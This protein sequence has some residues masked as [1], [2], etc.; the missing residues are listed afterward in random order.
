MYKKLLL[1]IITALLISTGIAQAEPEDV[2]YFDLS[3]AGYRLGMTFDE[4][5]EV[6]PF[7]YIRDNQ[8]NS[9]DV[10]VM[11]A[12]IDQVYIDDI[13]T[14]LWLSFRSG[15]ISKII[16]RFSP[17]ALEDMSRRFKQALGKGENRSK[18]FT[19]RNGAEIQQTICQW[20]FPHA[21]LHL[22]K[23]SSNT[24]YATI[25]LVKKIENRKA[26]TEKADDR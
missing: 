3:L 12:Y 7:Q 9:D 5:A 8:E 25:S 23:I 17:D 24:E 13:E 16:V 20:D 4:A 6:R 2:V 22:V 19:D 26:S 21:K 11:D 14:N 18:M 10:P 1:F 15:E